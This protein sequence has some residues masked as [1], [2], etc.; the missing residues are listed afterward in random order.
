MTMA[1][2]LSHLLGNTACYCLPAPPLDGAQ[3]RHGFV[4]EI[5]VTG[6]FAL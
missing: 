6:A 4:T 1:N 2:N 3:S 5:L